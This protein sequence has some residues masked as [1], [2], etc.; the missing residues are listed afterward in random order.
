MRRKQCRKNTT[1]VEHNR[2]IWNKIFQKRTKRKQV[3][4]AGL[5]RKSNEIKMHWINCKCKWR[6][7]LN[8]TNIGIL[9]EARQYTLYEDLT[10]NYRVL[11]ATEQT[12]S[13]IAPK[14]SEL[15]CSKIR[16]FSSMQW[17]KKNQCPIRCYMCIWPAS[18]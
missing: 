17:I 2:N 8:W 16:Q 13:D 1:M 11:F 15:S 18:N 7:I 3:R 12:I 5:K 6:S 10:K 4:N 14:K 9:K